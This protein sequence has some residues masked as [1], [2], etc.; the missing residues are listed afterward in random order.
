MMKEHRIL[1]RFDPTLDAAKIHTKAGALR[2]LNLRAKKLDA[3]L[4]SEL[5]PLRKK[6]A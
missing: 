2:A 3:A 4:E 1:P 6:S 5:R